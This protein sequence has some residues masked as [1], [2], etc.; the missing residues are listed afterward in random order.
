MLEFAG[1]ASVIGM[2]VDF[3]LLPLWEGATVQGR[4]DMIQERT[5]GMVL[6]WWLVGH[7]LVL[8]FTDDDSADQVTISF[9]GVFLSGVLHVRSVSR[10]V[11]DSN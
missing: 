2:L 11:S 7:G 5:A 6:I 8:T 9:L 3:C 1:F 4:I 10:Y